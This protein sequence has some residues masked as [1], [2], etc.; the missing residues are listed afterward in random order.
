MT[1]P[2]T[3]LT[4]QILFLELTCGGVQTQ[5]LQGGWV[6]Q[7]IWYLAAFKNAKATFDSNSDQ[8]NF[9]LELPKAEDRDQ[10]FKF[11]TC[12]KYDEGDVA[13]RQWI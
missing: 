2:M 5:N 4:V 11:P 6:V 1:E 9:V 8:V 10:E 13:R 3:D 12:C 7:K